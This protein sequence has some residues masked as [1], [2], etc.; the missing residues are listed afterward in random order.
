MGS[1][2]DEVCKFQDNACAC[3]PA[4]LRRNDRIM[5]DIP[6]CPKAIRKEHT[7]G[8]IEIVFDYDLELL[9]AL[10]QS[11]HSAFLSGS[12]MCL[13]NRGFSILVS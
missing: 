1:F 12:Q 3:L 13:L 8:A 10:S 4:F 11:S 5:H 6:V 7:D 9:I 2:F